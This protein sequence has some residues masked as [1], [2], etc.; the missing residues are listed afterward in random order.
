MFTKNKRGSINIDSEEDDFVM[1]DASKVTAYTI[2]GDISINLKYANAIGDN[3]RNTNYAIRAGTASMKV[4]DTSK[5]SMCLTEPEEKK[6]EEK[7]VEEKK[8]VKGF[9]LKM[10]NNKILE[11]IKLHLHNLIMKE[12]HEYGK[13]SKI[14]EAG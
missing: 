4:A 7:K 12:L 6:V 13:A 5:I 10:S 9:G 11:A 8:P 14:L 3:S 1:G 2:G